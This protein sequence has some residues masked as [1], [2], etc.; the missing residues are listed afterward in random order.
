MQAVAEHAGSARAN[1]DAW[2]FPRIRPALPSDIDGLMDMCRV[3]FDENGIG[4]QMDEGAVLAEITTAIT[5]SMTGK[6]RGFLGVIG[7]EGKIEGSL[8]LVTGCV[9]YNPSYLWLEDRWVF[10]LPE[11][12]KSK[13]G[14]TSNAVELVKCAEYISQSLGL[15]LMI[16]ILNNTRTEAKVRLYRRILGEPAGAFFLKGARTGH[17]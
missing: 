10:V 9:W 15:P 5:R 1:E 3:M 4:P 16:G 14:Q 7:D 2:P 17:H 6:P 11:H 12:R 13:P 8:F